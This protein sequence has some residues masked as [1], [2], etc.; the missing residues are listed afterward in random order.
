MKLT[1]LEVY[2]FTKISCCRSG[3]CIL[4][5]AAN[6]E[7]FF[8]GKNYFPKTTTLVANVLSTDNHFKT[9]Y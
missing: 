6:F 4:L 3:R 2:K 7:E 8:Y 5:Q 9:R 1:D